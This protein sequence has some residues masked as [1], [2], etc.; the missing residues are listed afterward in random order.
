[1]DDFLELLHKKDLADT[2][3]PEYQWVP[4]DLATLFTSELVATVFARHVVTYH[5]RGNIFYVI[6]KGVNLCQQ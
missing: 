4:F 3:E 5:H 2:N 6:K 1:M